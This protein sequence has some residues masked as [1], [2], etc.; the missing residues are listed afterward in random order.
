[1]IR[2][3]LTQCDFLTV[4]ICVSDQEQLPGKMRKSWMDETFAGITNLDIRIFDYE[5]A[6]LPN[7]S[8]SSETIS[9]IWATAFSRLLPDH[10]L[11]ITSEPYGAYVARFMGIQHIPF[12]PQRIQVPVS[13]TAIRKDPAAWWKFLP[14]S[15]KPDLNV[16]VVIL[17][18]ESTGKT[19]LT[20]QLADHFHATAVL[21]AGRDLIDDSN[22]FSIDDLY[23][24]ANAHATI[25]DDASRGNSPLLIIDTDVHITISYGRY[26]FATAL[27]LSPEIFRKNR[28]DIYL[29]LNNDV[30]FVQDGTRLS[31]EERDKLDA[32]HRQTL[33]DYHIPFE[34]IT[35]NW[36]ERFAKAVA[37]T[38]AAMERKIDWIAGLASP[39][40]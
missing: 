15:V 24:V 13:A 38:K 5:E 27:D 8:V 39:H 30:P 9:E 32:F 29:Y 22:E 35:G 20:A 12:D 17:G 11:L 40:T 19:T 16:K 6:L 10:T 31:Q 4:L 37:L 7:S 18:T 23:L 3:A 14:S 36:E 1:M 28:A 34:E 26:A 21:E 33:Q 25:I 2:F